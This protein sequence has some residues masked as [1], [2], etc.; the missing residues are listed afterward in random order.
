MPPRL[1]THP[2]KSLVK[3]VAKL[4]QVNPIQT[5]NASEFVIQT[6]AENFNKKIWN[7]IGSS[8]VWARRAW[9]GLP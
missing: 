9:S 4:V 2:A 7:R 1:S 5:S 3:Y 6:D 8:A